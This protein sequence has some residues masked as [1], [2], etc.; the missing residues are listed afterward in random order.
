MKIRSGVY[1]SFPGTGYMKAEFYR[2]FPFLP[3]RIGKTLYSLDEISC[4]DGAACF[5]CT[6]LLI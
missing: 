2:L 5:A 4:L 1:F 6:R 3:A